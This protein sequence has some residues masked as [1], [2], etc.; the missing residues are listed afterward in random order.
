MAQDIEWKGFLA[1]NDRYADII[2]GICCGGK[3]VVNGSDLHELDSQVSFLRGPRFVRSW[4]PKKSR[5]KIKI[6]DTLRKAAFGVNFAIIGIENQE[7]KVDMCKA[8]K[9]LIEVGRE[10]GREVGLRALVISLSLLLPDSDTVYQAV[11]KNED[12]SNVSKEQVMKYYRR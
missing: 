2:N 6:R 12:Y 5:R 4:N 3:Q 10:E 7:V 11:I 1:D 9:E 8:I